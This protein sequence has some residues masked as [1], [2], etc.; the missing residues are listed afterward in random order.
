MCFEYPA[1]VRFRCLRCGICCGDTE[2]KIRCI[3][4]LRKEVELIAIATEQPLSEFAVKVKG[5][6]PYTYEMKKVDGKCVFFKN[7][8]CKIYSIRPLVCRFYPFELKGAFD[9]KY[10][11]LY[12]SECKGINKGGVLSKNYF[13]KLFRLAC[14]RMG[15]WQ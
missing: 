13:K 10:L 7:G 5:K 2:E 15:E 11:F 9:G 6:E 12:T 14:L 8:G 1:T 4:L 3:L